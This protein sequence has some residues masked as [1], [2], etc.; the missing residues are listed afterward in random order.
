MRSTAQEIIGYMESL[1]DKE[2]RLQLMRFLVSVASWRPVLVSALCHR[3]DVGD[4]TEAVD[5]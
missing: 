2:Q 3:K 1:H 5:D 4:G